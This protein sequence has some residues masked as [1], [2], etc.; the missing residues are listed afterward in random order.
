MTSD[1]G[2]PE[3]VWGSRIRASEFAEK[4]W[5]EW[6][7]AVLSLEHGLTARAALAPGE[8]GSSLQSGAVTADFHRQL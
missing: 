3:P 2:A 8:G 5:C 7:Q 1:P 6:L 4:P